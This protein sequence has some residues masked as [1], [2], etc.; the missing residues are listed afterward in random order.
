VAQAFAAS[1][2]CATPLDG[3]AC[4]ACAHCAR[5]AAGT[6]PDLLLVAREPERR[7]IRTE[8]AREVGR[9]LALRPLVAERKIALL[10]D[11]EHLNEHG[12]NALLKTL[13]EPPGAA[14]LVLVAAAAALLLPTV[15]SRC[16]RLRLQPPEPQALVPLLI[17]LGVPA[18]R[19]PALAALA[20]GSAGRALELADEVQERARATV[21]AQLPRLG[22]RS[23]AELSKLAQELG[24]GATDAALAAAV[25]WYRDVL[26]IALDAGLRLHDPGAADA[27]ADAAATR[28]PSAILRQLELV[29]DTIVAVEQN[30]N[31]QLVLETMLL[32]LR[33][34]ERAAHRG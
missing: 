2:L 12:Q 33:E 1:L 28:H 24:G 30:A 25:A 6:H 16:Q 10:D 27:L 17:A 26:G 32:D 4:G 22:E 9:W 13:E 11:A 19:A 18:E 15:R 21:I 8:Q 14:V 7:D 5:A 29:C 31:R 3:D 34:I 23:A 20:E